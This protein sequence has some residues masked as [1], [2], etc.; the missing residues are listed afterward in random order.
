MPGTSTVVPRTTN[1]GSEEWFPTTLSHPPAPTNPAIIAKNIIRISGGIYLNNQRV[2]VYVTESDVQLYRHCK[3]V[4]EPAPAPAPGSHAA[5]IAAKYA[6][7]GG[8]RVAPK[9]EWSPGA[10]QNKIRIRVRNSAGTVVN[11]FVVDK[12]KLA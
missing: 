1:R 9:V 2:E 3:A 7:P 11:V 5:K 4:M 8:Q 6:A 10:E 12:F